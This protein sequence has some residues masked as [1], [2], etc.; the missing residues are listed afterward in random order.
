MQKLCTVSL[1]TF[2]AAQ[3]VASRPGG[4][5]IEKCS[6]LK[7]FDFWFDQQNAGRSLLDP[8]ANNKRS[9]YKTWLSEARSLKKALH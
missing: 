8:V 6:K 7:I 9:P 3:V 2:Q 1:E 4:A 5:G